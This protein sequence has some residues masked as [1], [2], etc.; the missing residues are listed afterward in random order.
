MDYIIIPGTVKDAVQQDVK[1]GDYVVHA[2]TY[3]G[4]QLELVPC[5]V[6]Q[7]GTKVYK[8]GGRDP[9]AIQVKKQGMDRPI[10]LSPSRLIKVQKKWKI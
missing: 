10:W 1:K 9:N 3:K 7:A 4:G 2:K 6:L 8:T 5:K